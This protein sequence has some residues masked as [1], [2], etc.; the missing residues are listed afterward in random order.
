MT[1]QLIEELAN[2]TTMED[3]ADAYKPV[4]ELIGLGNML[5]LSQYSMGD[6]IYFPKA[7]RILAPARNRKIRQDYN[8]YN[9]KDLATA[10]DLTTNQIMQI[11][12][13][14]DPQQISMFEDFEELE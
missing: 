2:E 7:E 10:Y 1:R 14:M 4:V 5:K 13:D 6:K 3:I 11:V 9:S 12:R 8:G